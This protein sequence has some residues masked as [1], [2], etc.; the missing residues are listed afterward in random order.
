[1]WFVSFFVFA[2]I[3]KHNKNRY[4]ICLGGWMFYEDCAEKNNRRARTIAINNWWVQWAHE[5]F[6]MNILL[7]S[8]KRMSYFKTKSHI[9]WQTFTAKIYLNC[10]NV[11]QSVSIELE[12]S[13]KNKEIYYHIII[14]YMYDFSVYKSLDF[15][16]D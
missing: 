16:N 12:V 6:S 9:I 15:S 11:G 8:P 13:Q 1:M 3:C 10:Q 5:S 14:W 7:V 2:S 4:N